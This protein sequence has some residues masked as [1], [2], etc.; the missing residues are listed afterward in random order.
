MKKKLFFL[1]AIALFAFISC[2]NADTAEVATSDSVTVVEGSS[3]T[4][5]PSAVYSLETRQPV[6]VEYDEA[7]G[8][9]VEVSTRKPIGFYYDPISLDTFDS[10]GRIVN[11]ALILAEGGGYNLDEAKIKSDENSYKL[12]VDDLKI[13]VNEDGDTKLKT[14]DI[15]IKETDDKLKIK[16]DDGKIKV[17]DGEVKV[18]D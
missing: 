1:P 6:E 9:Y 2:N 10:R 17:K 5:Q 18:K 16:T 7:S 3:S 14:D 12:K 13:K 15:K 11:N 8:Q 4:D